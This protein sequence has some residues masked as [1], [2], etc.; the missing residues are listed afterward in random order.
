MTLM[1]TPWKPHGD[2]METP[3]GPHEEPMGP[4]GIPMG[5][6]WGPHGAGRQLGGSQEAIAR[7]LFDHFQKPV[8]VKIDQN[9]ETVAKKLVPGVRY[10]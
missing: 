6:P 2:P 8:A 10:W 5:S 7:W 9:R 3:W 1:G 4:H